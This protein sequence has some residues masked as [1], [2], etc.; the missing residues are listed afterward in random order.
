MTWQNKKPQH[1]QSPGRRQTHETHSW[2][3]TAKST[4]GRKALTAPCL[5]DHLNKLS[6]AFQENDLP[7]VFLLWICTISASWGGG[8]FNYFSK[9]AGPSSKSSQLNTELILTRT[10]TASSRLCLQSTIWKNWKQTHAAICSI[11]CNQ[12]YHWLHLHCIPV[13]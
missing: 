9:E 13:C 2:Q 5:T 7:F 1:T 12:S 3:N 4:A 6:L 10:S 8:L 11:G